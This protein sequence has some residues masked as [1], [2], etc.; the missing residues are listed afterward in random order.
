MQV[1]SLC[2]P[3]PRSAAP[4]PG[5]NE[6]LV[7]RCDNV[8]WLLDGSSTPARLTKGCTP[9]SGYS[10]VQRLDE[11]LKT[12]APAFKERP[13]VE[14][15]TK[16][17]TVYDPLPFADD[18]QV[19]QYTA[20]HTCVVLV[21]VERG[22]LDYVLLQDAS[23]LVRVGTDGPVQHLKDCRQDHFNKGHY[24]R[25][26]Q[27][28]RT[29]EGFGGPGVNT[30]LDRMVN[31]ERAHRNKSSG[32]WTFTGLPGAAANAVSGTVHF[33][34][35]QGIEVLLASDGAARW[36]EVFGGDPEN[37]FSTP[38][39][40]VWGSVQAWEQQD[41]TGAHAPRIGQ[42]DDFSLLRLR[43]PRCEGSDEARG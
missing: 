40:A 2:R 33:E 11:L 42:S 41:P 30:E 43:V 14:L 35:G 6:D 18:L 13:L 8:F 4:F 19:L 22:H 20:P 27:H 29:G 15:L 21:R 12:H 16:C 31:R 23:L 36:W 39:T 7:G 38:L 37:L 17:E 32:F 10:L 34:P 3:K 25:L 28:L 5:Y 1:D 9:L 26:W 24:D